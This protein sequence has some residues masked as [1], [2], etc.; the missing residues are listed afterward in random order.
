MPNALRLATTL[1]VV[2]AVVVSHFGWLDARGG[3]HLDAAFQRALVAFAL[4][5]TLNGV[6]S[7]VQETQVALQPAGVGVT[8]APGEL[9]DPL[10]DLVERFSYVMLASSAAIGIER[11]LLAMSA[12]WG[13]T[14]AL[15]IAGV[16]WLGATWLGPGP[17]WQAIGARVLVALVFVRFAIP[18]LLIA[19]QFVSTTF[20]EAQ[21]KA[22]TDALQLTTDQAREL[23]AEVDAAARAANDA[24]ML[25]RL[26][27]TLKSFDVKARIDAL[28]DGLA[29]AIGHIVDLIVVFALETVLVPLAF[30]WLLGKLLAALLR[31]V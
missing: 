24:S 9:L 6:I 14:I 19:T 2:L 12:W 29:G 21:A 3:E 1:L 26:T 20:L 15:A 28:R 27:S 11:V 5:R 10:N 8:L 17:R 22:A 25:E 4:A 13:V 18:V 16:A 7:V 30:L 23:D 31:R